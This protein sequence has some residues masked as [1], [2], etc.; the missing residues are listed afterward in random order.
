[1]QKRIIFIFLIFIATL[2][3]GNATN[4][5]TNV[6]VDG[7]YYDWNVYYIDDLSGNKK[8][9]IASFA[10]N[11]IGNYKKERKPYIMIAYFS[12]KNV[13]ETSIY[14][15]YDYKLGS[16]IYISINNKQF[17]MFTKGRMAWTKTVEE[18]KTIVNELLK[19]KEIKTRGE[20]LMGEY[21]VDTYSTKG[22]ARAYKRMKE[23]CD[24]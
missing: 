8:C 12:N 22:L 23:L 24:I 14:A 19:A 6:I 2:A 20:T 3:K 9:Y 13:V 16:Y 10:T 21:T 11:S 18:D 1:M 15:D 5:S 4:S 7:A 17:R